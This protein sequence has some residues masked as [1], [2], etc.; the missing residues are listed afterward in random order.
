M[1]S[2]GEIYW[3]CVCAC[4]RA[5]TKVKKGKALVDQELCKDLGQDMLH[6]SKASL[7]LE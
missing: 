7:C 6:I 3:L 1:D 4:V 2:Y 5:K